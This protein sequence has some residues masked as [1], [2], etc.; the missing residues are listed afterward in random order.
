VKDQHL[1]CTA[2]HAFGVD[3]T[4]PVIRVTAQAQE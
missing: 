1:T 3:R 4:V 2:V